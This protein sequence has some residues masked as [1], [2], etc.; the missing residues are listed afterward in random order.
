MRVSEKRAHFKNCEDR[1]CAECLMFN[2][3]SLYNV[4]HM[5]KKKNP[6]KVN[7]QSDS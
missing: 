2:V 6:K 5:Q 7:T 1:N 3:D 4:L